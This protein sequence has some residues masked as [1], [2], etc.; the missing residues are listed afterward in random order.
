MLRGVRGRSGGGAGGRAG[1]GA[2]GR[3]G[4]GRGGHLDLR[5]RRRVATLWV[6]RGNT[7]L[8]GQQW[9][10]CARRKTTT[11]TVA[12]RLGEVGPKGTT[13]SQT[14][15]TDRPP[16]FHGS[17]FPG[18]PPSHLSAPSHAPNRAVLALE[19]TTVHGGKKLPSAHLQAIKTPPLEGG[20]VQTG[21]GSLSATPARPAPARRR[22]R[23]GVGRRAATGRPPSIVDAI[24]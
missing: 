11:A 3:G 24:P 10:S 13:W 5:V 21:G 20:K 2:V 6:E 1:L 4:G 19:H 8:P 23:I 9:F 12:T 7:L 17:T 18:F 15:T 14:T 16:R 22:L